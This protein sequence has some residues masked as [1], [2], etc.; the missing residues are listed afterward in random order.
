MQIKYVCSLGPF[1]HSSLFL[2]NNK[3]KK[4]SYPFDWIISSYN[5]IIDCI[6]DD[7]K[8]FLDKSYY[9]KISNNEYRHQYYKIKW[10]H[11]NPLNDENHYNYYVRC[12]NRFKELL[13]YEEHK[14]FIMIFFD[15]K[16]NIKNDIINFNNE[17][18]KYTKNYTLLIIY[19]IQNKQD[20]DHI[21]THHDNIDFLELSNSN[22]FHNIFSLNNNDHTYL[23]NIINSKYKFNIE[24]NI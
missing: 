8:I 4:C 17:F 9:L 2:K 16:E 22:I 3:L 11:H 13:T 14:L 24:T 10:Y 21:F 23:N 5:N 7:F 15:V 1:C 12:V 6:K 19:N 18:Y 20:N